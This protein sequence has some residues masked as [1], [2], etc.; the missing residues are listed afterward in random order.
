M[1]G[2]SEERLLRLVLGHSLRSQPGT[3][4]GGASEG[5]QG[6][7]KRAAN[8]AAEH[9]RRLRLRGDVRSFGSLC[10][11]APVAAQKREHERGWSPAES[12]FS[13]RR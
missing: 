13:I 10:G 7:R 12:G 11:L 8:G 4:F 1:A 5:R 9:D 6:M 3:L 2:R